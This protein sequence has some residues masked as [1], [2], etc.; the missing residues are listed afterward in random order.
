MYSITNFPPTPFHHFNYFNVCFQDARVYPDWAFHLNDLYRDR[1]VFGFHLSKRLHVFVNL[2]TV[3][4]DALG[5]LATGL[6]EE[7]RTDFWGGTGQFKRLPVKWKWRQEQRA[8]PSS[9][10]SR[11]RGAC[12]VKNFPVSSHACISTCS[13][14]SSLH[15]HHTPWRAVGSLREAP[16]DDIQSFSNAFGRERWLDFNPRIHVWLLGKHKQKPA[17]DT[18]RENC[19]FYWG[20]WSIENSFL[21]VE[22][23]RST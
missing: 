15:S 8:C 11:A 9:D 18:G 14:I 22:V 21:K 6:I 20:R 3:L 23:L 17:T 13:W 16:G 10:N 12:G 5:S 1:R 7:I 19:L 2:A 4:M